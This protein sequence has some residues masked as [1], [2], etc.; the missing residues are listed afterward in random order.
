MFIWM[1][2]RCAHKKAKYENQRRNLNNNNKNSNQNKNAGI[3][4][5]ILQHTQRRIITTTTTKTTK[6]KIST[7]AVA[8]LF[9]ITARGADAVEPPVSPTD[10]PPPGLGPEFTDGDGG[11]V[12]AGAGPELGV[13]GGP[14][15]NNNPPP[16]NNIMI[17]PGQVSGGQGNGP[18]GDRTRSNGGGGF[19]YLGRYNDS[20][21]R[22]LPF[23][24]E[25]FKALIGGFDCLGRY[26]EVVCE[27][28]EK[29]I[30]G[31]RE[32]QPFDMEEFKAL[33]ELVKNA[34]PVDP[35]RIALMDATKNVLEKQKGKDNVKKFNLLLD[36]IEEVADEEL[37]EKLHMD[38]ERGYSEADPTAIIDPRDGVIEDMLED[39]IG[40][41]EDEEGGRRLGVVKA[42]RK[43]PNGVLKVSVLR[44]PNNDGMDVFW[45]RM[46]PAMTEIEQL[47]GLSFQLGYL[48]DAPI[49]DGHL[50]LDTNTPPDVCMV[51]GIGAPSSTGYYKIFL[52]TEC[53]HG[54]IMHEI[55]H[56]AGMHHQQNA[57]YRDSYINVNFENIDPRRASQFDKLNGHGCEEVYDY[58]SIM[59][60]RETA[61]LKEGLP[62]D[63]KAID[64]R[65]HICGQRDGLSAWDQIEIYLYYF[66][67][68][69]L[70]W[71]KALFS[72][73]VSFRTFHG[74]YLQARPD[75]FLYQQ[76]FSSTWETFFLE[77]DQP[78][79]EQYH[80]RTH[81]G[82][83]LK[84]APHGSAI[85]TVA[86]KS[87][88]T[89]FTLFE[90]ANYP[91]KVGLKSVS[92]GT[93]VQAPPSIDTLVS[94]WQDMYPWESYEMISWN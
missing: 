87:S 46:F 69:N 94:S 71:N 27:Q 32:G 15:G 6:M 9:A 88:D 61:F 86:S 85:Q 50:Y 16:G 55:L 20:A 23:D 63:A 2:I 36:I 66:D 5:S 68:P 1:M 14:D 38:L 75:G 62:P 33:K 67:N 79:S 40:P 24:M 29:I 17:P 13:I 28:M 25:E 60:Y 90:H 30:D 81:H 11:A 91:G 26:N 22:G 92:L 8:F 77:E 64:C 57:Y 3:T 59:H 53:S 70:G 80:I 45:N 52:G 49:G 51:N 19:D 72:Q 48:R 93:F 82:R 58:G 12:G 54:N 7:L 39:G 43:W 18:P 74:N 65:G 21:R 35:K 37:K 42:D 41:G 34:L 73:N 89:L 83:Y 10:G 76:T 44:G 84:G 4:L 31:A 56:A 47:T 78:G